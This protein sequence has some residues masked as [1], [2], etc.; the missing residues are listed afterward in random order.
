LN[1]ILSSISADVIGAARLGRTWPQ[2]WIKQ[3]LNKSLSPLEGFE[4]FRS[5]L[6]LPASMRLERKP[7]RSL[8][9]AALT[10]ASDYL[11]V[12]PGGE[13]FVNLPPRVIGQGD[14]RVL[15]G[16]MRSMYVAAFQEAT[17][18]GRSGFI[19]LQDFVLLDFEGDEYQRIDDEIEL[20]SMVFHSERDSAWFITDGDASRALHIDQGFSLLGPNSFAFGHWLVEYLPKVMIAIQSGLL[21]TIP[22]LIDAG[23]ARQHRQMLELLL[24]SG[25]DI[26]EVRPMQDVHARK[27]WCAPTVAYHPILARINQRFRYDYIAGPPIRFARIVQAML[28][29]MVPVIGPASGA[30]RLYLA[31]KPGSHRKMVN[32]EEIEAIAARYGFDR[33]YLEDFDFV[34]Q[35]KLLRSARFLVG[36]DGSAFFTAFFSRP[37][38]RLCI[39]NHPHTALMPTVTALA[40]ALGLES[41]VLTGPF[42]REDPDYPNHADYEIDEQAFASFLEHWL[43]ESRA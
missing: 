30:N 8:R 43:L 33:V 6:G 32:R 27:L 7:I 29:R 23:M 9:A 20:D 26:I 24:P 2:L 13:A 34:D 42:Y 10:H 39:L 11:E 37:G 40:D 22:M 16:V 1:Q 15:S 41:T 12:E 35:L 17:T 3:E 18:R 36:P 25:A 14:H 5:T 21:P 4:E 28:E 38:T 31:R 19:G